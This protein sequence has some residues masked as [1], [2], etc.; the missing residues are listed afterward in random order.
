M[1]IKNEAV[2]LYEVR[3]VGIFFVLQVVNGDQIT[4]TRKLDEIAEAITEDHEV[5]EAHEEG[6][7]DL[8]QIESWREELQAFVTDC[9]FSE[10]FE[11]GDE[12]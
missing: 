2:F 5:L 3:K 9:K 8:N 1:S 12:D 6:R 4:K 11:V 7:I 10:N